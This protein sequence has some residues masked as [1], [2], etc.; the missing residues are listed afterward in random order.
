M[1]TTI[2]KIV[3]WI[4]T[5]KEIWKDL[6]ARYDRGN[7]YRLSDFLETFHVKK[8][9]SMSIDEYFTTLKILWD[10][11]LMLRSIPACTCV[12]TCSCSVVKTVRE[13]KCWI[14]HEVC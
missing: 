4:N 8:Q 7:A 14:C 13:Y 11:T 12:P 9:G 1:N 3:M 5:A 2:K 6:E 10:E